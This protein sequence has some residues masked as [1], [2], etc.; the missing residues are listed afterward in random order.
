MFKTTKYEKYFER[1]FFF[2]EVSNPSL[3]TQG[4]MV[5]AEKSIYGKEE[6]SGKEKSRIRKKLARIDLFP[7]TVLNCAPGTSRMSLTCD[8]H[9]LMTCSHGGGGPQVA[10]V[11][12]LGGV[13][14]LSYFLDCF[15]MRGGVHVPGLVGL[16]G[17]PCQVTCLGGVSFLH[18]NAEG[19]EG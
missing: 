6:N 16:P 10:E 19:G 8:Y 3:E 7:H 11:P 1:I 4:Q 17:Q 13:T 12:R 9:Q 18:V 14:N 5:R 15:H 2:F